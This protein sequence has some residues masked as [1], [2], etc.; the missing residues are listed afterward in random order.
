MRL[1]GIRQDLLK[2]R[3][4]FDL[5]IMHVKEE[6]TQ[7]LTIQA[8]VKKIIDKNNQQNNVVIQGIPLDDSLEDK[9]KDI[10]KMAI[11][12]TNKKHIDKCYRLRKT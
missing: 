4:T 12:S 11:R 6:L 10:F 5:Q 3:N 1:H 9:D 8:N 2:F 7:N